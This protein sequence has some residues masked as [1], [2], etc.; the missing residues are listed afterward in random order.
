MEAAAVGNCT[1][2][3]ARRRS[4]APPPAPAQPRQ[5]AGSSVP[6]VRIQ[7][8]LLAIADW[9]SSVFAAQLRLQTHTSGH[10][11]GAHDQWQTARLLFRR[12]GR[13]WH[14]L[15]IGKSSEIPNHLIIS[16]A[17]HGPISQHC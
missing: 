17:V 14:T 15:N 11:P 13:V 9:M 8:R 12:T 10:G 5:E 3:G 4:P 1:G 6:P 2:G 16:R 7:V